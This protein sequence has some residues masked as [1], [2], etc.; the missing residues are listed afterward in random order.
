MKTVR[1]ISTGKVKRIDKSLAKEVVSLGEAEY[2]ED[3]VDAINKPAEVNKEVKMINPVRETKPMTETVDTENGKQNAA[4]A[5]KR[6]RKTK[7]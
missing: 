5:N 7:K 6:G 3:V 1:M 4:T 2:I